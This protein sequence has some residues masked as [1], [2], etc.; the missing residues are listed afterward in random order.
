MAV[1]AS[2]EHLLCSLSNHSLFSLPLS[3]IDILKPDEM[4]FELLTHAVSH[5]PAPELL[6]GSS[7]VL[8]GS[9]WW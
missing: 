3:N 9:L 2:E 5:L 4:N 8:V 7:Q 6:S 1:S